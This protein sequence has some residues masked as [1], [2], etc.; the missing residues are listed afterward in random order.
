[1]A[2]LYDQYSVESFPY[3]IGFGALSIILFFTLRFKWTISLLPLLLVAFASTAFYL[4]VTQAINV[5]GSTGTTFGW[6]MFN[7]LLMGELFHVIGFVSEEVSKGKA[8]LG[9]IA[10]CYSLYTP[11]MVKII[12]GVLVLTLLGF[13]PAFSIPPEY[14]GLGVA[15]IAGY[16]VL[17]HLLVPVIISLCPYQRLFSK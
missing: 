4:E 13:I 8:K 5:L 7:A 3:L 14:I 1:L 17:L 9:A 12:A 6:A 10:L 11:K 2:L 15:L 16:S